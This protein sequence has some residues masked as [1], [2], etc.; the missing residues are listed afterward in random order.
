M[1]KSTTE[2]G[3][4]II[5]QKMERKRE[6]IQQTMEKKRERKREKEKVLSLGTTP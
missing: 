4:E 1:R 2:D 3:K 5:Q 6:R